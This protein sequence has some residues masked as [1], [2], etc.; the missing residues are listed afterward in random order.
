[1][2]MEKTQDWTHEDVFLTEEGVGSEKNQVVIAIS[3]FFL[4]GDL[5]VVL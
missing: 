1:M 2:N 5:E 4:F 3:Y